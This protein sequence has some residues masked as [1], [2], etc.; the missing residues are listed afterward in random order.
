MNDIHEKSLADQLREERFTTKEDILT[1]L[2]L[3]ESR[4]TSKSQ[5][6]KKHSAA[7]YYAYIKLMN[8]FYK[9][10]E[11]TVLFERLEDFWYYSIG[12]D[13]SGASLSLVYTP[14]C[15]RNDKGTITVT[16]GQELSLLRVRAGFL[17]V[18]QYAEEYGV[19]LVTVRQW[20][21]R[22]KLRSAIKVGNTWV[23][24]ELT[25][26]PG[27]GYQSASYAYN[28]RLSDVPEEY[29]FLQGYTCVI[30]NQD[31]A[32]KQMFEVILAAGNKEPK[33]MTLDTKEREKLELYLI[34]NPEIHYIDGPSDGLNI[35]I[36]SKTHVNEDL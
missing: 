2:K 30:I 8:Q 28:G 27:R 33:H 19:S 12:I 7:F 34:S 31:M 11:E 9:K 6:D 21:R 13:S 24:P 20:I 16:V 10:I 23:I 15:W 1:W 29:E 32:D 3:E 5:T 35:A 18:N 36:S 4:I 25:D 17:S 22:G 14:K 26:L